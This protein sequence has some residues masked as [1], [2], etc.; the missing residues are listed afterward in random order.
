MADARYSTTILSFADR[1]GVVG[2]ALA[3]PL[4]DPRGLVGHS[5][6]YFAQL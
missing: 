1:N 4:G 3:S 2:D 5:V 6:A